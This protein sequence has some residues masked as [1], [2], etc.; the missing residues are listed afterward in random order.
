MPFSSQLLIRCTSLSEGSESLQH[1]GFSSV[2]TGPNINAHCAKRAYGHVHR[3]PISS[4]YG[5]TAHLVPQAP[6][7]G[8]RTCRC[9]VRAAVLNSLAVRYVN[10]LLQQ[11]EQREA[12]FDIGSVTPS[13]CRLRARCDLSLHRRRDPLQPCRV[14]PLRPSQH[15]QATPGRSTSKRTSAHRHRDAVVV[16]PMRSAATRRGDLHRVQTATKNEA[17][18]EASSVAFPAPTMPPRPSQT[19]SRIPL[20]PCD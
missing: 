16:V 18:P 2:R 11:L 10:T 7:Y 3:T 14:I 5:R 15:P 1:L 19:P 20:H 6:P 9:E 4:A 12:R 8:Y 17:T 13:R